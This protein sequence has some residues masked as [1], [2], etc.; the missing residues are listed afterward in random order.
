MPPHVL[1]QIPFA[2]GP[3]RVVVGLTCLVAVAVVFGWLFPMFLAFLRTL[4][5]RRAMQNAVGGA[6][7][8]VVLSLGLVPMIFLVASITNP[9]TFVTES[10]VVSES[11]LHGKPKSFA[12][13]EIDH[14]DCTA[15][16]EG[17]INS[18]TIV[19]VDG[20]R[21]AVGD[22]AVF[23][24]APLHKL[25]LNQLGPKVVPNCRTARQSLPGL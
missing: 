3:V 20:R 9:K 10:G 11:I 24:L 21:I 18:L 2:S 16:R 8:L 17:R 4:S 5:S 14:V 19:A 6:L 25:L 1:Y 7:F 22:F 23:D 12:W 15:A 13:S